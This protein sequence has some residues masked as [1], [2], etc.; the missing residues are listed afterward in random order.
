MTEAWSLLDE[1]PFG[2]CTRAAAGT[3]LRWN[4]RLA[5]W[6]GAAP[7]DAVGKAIGEVLP[8]L[9]ASAESHLRVEVTDGE[10]VRRLLRF[11]QRTLDGPDHGEGTTLITAAD[12]GVGGAEQDH[13]HQRYASI[14]EST[15][16]AIIGYSPDGTIESWNQGAEELIGFT[17]GEII[18]EPL[19]RLAP[20]RTAKEMEELLWMAHQ[21]LTCTDLEVTWA[22]KDDQQLELSLTLSPIRLADGE[23]VGSAVIARDITHPK[24]NERE[25]MEYAMEVEEHR[26]R[27]EEQATRLVDQSGLLAQARDEALQASRAKA[28]FLSTMSHEIRTP[29]NGVIGMTEVLLDSALS[30]EQLDA[31]HTIRSS[32]E[33]LL[34][35]IND[36]LDLS[37]IEAGR[38]TFEMVPFDLRD[39]L[40]D[41]VRMMRQSALDKGITLDID[42]LEGAPEYIDG[43]PCRLRQVVINLVGNAIKFT[44]E[45]GVLVRVGSEPGDSGDELTTIE[46]EDTGVGIPPEKLDLIFEAFGQ[47]DSSTTRQFGGT[48]L[49]LSI[50]VRIC[51]ALGGE[52]TVVSEVGVGSTFRVELPLRRCEAPVEEDEE[53][54]LG[55]LGSGLRVLLVEDNKINQK[56]A[57]AALK[58]L[59]CEATVTE[60]GREAIERLER[61]SFDILLMDIQMPILNGIDATL[62]IRERQLAGGLPIIAMTANAMPEDRQRCLDS[63]MDGY[64]VKPFRRQELEEILLSWCRGGADEEDRAA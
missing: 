23:V 61:E 54:R 43:D 2:L 57:V 35:I 58:K 1:L 62:E 49:G 55:V 20:H 18:G 59:N 44:S 47:A 31:V 5:E 40:S 16:D 37:K 34:A 14:I 7:D 33:T 24:R 52:V 48:G 46:I 56:V 12:T 39:S 41:V 53:L 9:G 50:C 27:V 21:G 51:E 45:G 64:L 15:G 19:T 29:M 42:F 8:D 17:G 10:G 25:L 60:N 32:G 11:E 6:P 28:E 13:E 22:R 26:Q 3:L 30:Q 63:G 38:L 4:A 36:I